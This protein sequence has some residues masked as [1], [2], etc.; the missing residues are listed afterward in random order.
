MPR[1]CITF[2]WQLSGSSLIWSLAHKQ[3]RF[4]KVFMANLH[5]HAVESFSGD[6]LDQILSSKQVLRQIL[7]SADTSLVCDHKSIWSV[8]EWLRSEQDTSEL[9]AR[10]P[11]QNRQLCKNDKQKPSW[12][13]P[14]VSIRS[15]EPSPCAWVY[16]DM[17]GSLFS[18][19]IKTMQENVPW[20][21][22]APPKPERMGRWCTTCFLGQ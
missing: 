9:Q 15:I 16:T 10:N 4:L 3:S 7:Q 18:S 6:T 17:Y 11:D 5:D 19:R 22:R 1:P 12:G 2:G 8:L 20:D 14:R 13:V 21:C